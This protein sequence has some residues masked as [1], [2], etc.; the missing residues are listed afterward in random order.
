MR[1]CKTMFVSSSPAVGNS[2]PSGQAKTASL[3]VKEHHWPFT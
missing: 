3:S 1:G 2:Y